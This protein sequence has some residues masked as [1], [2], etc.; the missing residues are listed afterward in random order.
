[1]GSLAF[2]NARRFVRP[3][4]VKARMRLRLAPIV[5]VLVLVLV[6]CQ[7]EPP[8]DRGASPSV[9]EPPGT[10]FVACEL[11]SAGG[12]DDKS[13]NASAYAGLTRAQTELGVEPSVIESQAES[14]YAP[15]IEALIDKG[16]DLIVTIGFPIAGATF[17]AARDHPDQKFAI[18]DVGPID[19]ETQERVELDNVRELSFA[20]DEAAFLA[21]YLAAG[22]S[23]TGTIGTFGGAEI[24]PVT[25]IMDGF[26]AGIA[27]YDRDTVG[28]VRLIGWDP[29]NPR[30]GL[31][32]G[33]FV[34]QDAGRTAAEHLIGEGADIILPVAGPVGIGAAAVAQDA[35]DV[36]VIW[37]DTDGCVSA[38]EFCP[39]FL[40]SVVKNIDL[41]VFE[42]VKAM[43]EGR[44]V[45]GLYRGTLENG[46]VSIAPFHEFDARV[47]PELKSR[48]DELTQAIIDGSVSVD[49]ADYR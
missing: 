31:F 38:S 8:D 20:T 22:M 26:W 36:K 48:I 17:E 15:N 29:E 40:T 34:N 27:K 49:P 28:D 33:D 14:D 10:G 12:V 30:A 44:F 4:P 42:Q 19:P 13:F 47:P 16:C 35:D 46:G 11:T 9:G 45:G 1:M 24:P 21:G 3:R 18:V 37:I 43:V 5:P 7:G 6:A 41:A 25:R 23:G 39:Q 32:T 2:A